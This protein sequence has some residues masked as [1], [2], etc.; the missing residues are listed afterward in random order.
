MTRPVSERF[1]SKVTDAGSCWV[2]TA[3]RSR[4]G[5]GT[6]DVEGASQQA[7]RV[8]WALSHGPIPHGMLVCHHCDNPSCVRPE[9]LFLGTALDNSRDRIA[10]GRFP[11]RH[12]RRQRTGR[13]RAGTAAAILARYGP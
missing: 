9:H 1:W 7:H 11:A 10:K 12:P 2:W 13:L 4:R 6:F 5:Y 8:A 3:H